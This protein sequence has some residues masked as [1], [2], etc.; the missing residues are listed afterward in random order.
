[1]I[2]PGALLTSMLSG[3]LPAHQ[4]EPGIV[5]LKGEQL[6]AMSATS[7]LPFEMFKARLDYALK[8]SS[9]AKALAIVWLGRRLEISGPGC[10]ASGTFEGGH[11]QGLIE[12]VGPALLMRAAIFS[13]MVRM[14]RAAGCID[15]RLDEGYSGRRR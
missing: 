7:T 11:F 12:L 15:V 13:E 9:A 14:L 2:D 1:M 8:A 4:S 6:T 5:E 3:E 10:H